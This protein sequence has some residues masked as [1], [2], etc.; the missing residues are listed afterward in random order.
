MA[1]QQISTHAKEATKGHRDAANRP[2]HVDERQT[3]RRRP[4]GRA[5]AAE[6][7]QGASAAAATLP[8]AEV[9]SSVM[10]TDNKTAG[11]AASQ[12]RARPKRA[13][14]QKASSADRPPASSKRALLIG[15]LERA[16]G[17]SVAEIGQRL[18]WLPHT[19]RAAITGLRH[20]G[21]EVTRSKNES[22][23]TVYRLVPVETQGR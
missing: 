14:A 2:A 16:E 23:Q 20:A 4:Q 17:A 10:S 7:Q 18:G 8:E 19:V 1:R 12:P 21:R 5:R 3:R 22:G 6:V 9:D 15:M 11:R 13:G